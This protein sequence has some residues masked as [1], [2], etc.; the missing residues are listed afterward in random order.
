M[1]SGIR[2]VPE[3]GGPLTPELADGTSLSTRERA[4]TLEG[5][6]PE[7]GKP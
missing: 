6:F 3:S 5:Q 4:A 2:S 1:D 7:G